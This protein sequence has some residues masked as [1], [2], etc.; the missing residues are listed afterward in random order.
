MKAVLFLRAP[1]NQLLEK[2]KIDH[3]VACLAG[4]SKTKGLGDFARANNLHLFTENAEG[5]ELEA[6][7]ELLRQA[8]RHFTVEALVARPT[9]EEERT[10]LSAVCAMRHTKAIFF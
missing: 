5:A 8:R 9:S 6:L 7:N 4:F 3:K 1:D 2:A 10:R